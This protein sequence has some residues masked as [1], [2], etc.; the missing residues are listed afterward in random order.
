M[1]GRSANRKLG[2][3]GF[4]LAFVV[5]CG[6]T[7][8]QEIEYR[9]IFR[10]NTDGIE[11]ERVLPG[12][13]T[14]AW[15][16][17]LVIDPDPVDLR[18]YW[19]A[20][21]DTSGDMYLSAIRRATA[22]GENVH[23]IVWPRALGTIAIDS[24]HDKIYYTQHSDCVP[25][26]AISRAN[27]NGTGDEVV[28]HETVAGGLAID[29]LGGK[30][31]WAYYFDVDAIHCADLDGNGEQ[32]LITEAGGAG[33]LAVD[34]LAGKLYWVAYD[35]GAI[36]RA[37]LDG[38]EVEDVLTGL[39]WPAGLAIHPP[40]NRMWWS[41]YL[42]GKI[43]QAALDGSGVTDVLTGL[44]SPGAIGFLEAAGDPADEKLYWLSDP[45]PLSDD[46]P[47]AST[48]GAM[49][50][51]VLVLAASAAVLTRRRGSPLRR[52]ETQSD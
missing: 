17:P 30:I 3:A 10:A 44:D 5:L 22:D 20:L 42:E 9:S 33:S 45:A 16:S 18:L 51:V 31:Y 38:S 24:V 36:R 23:D 41:D 2:H 52:G 7:P 35:Q 11:V 15:S 39:S 25:C 43:Q 13:E 32:T 29:P 27:L 19:T 28:V 40:S 34:R 46:V 12:D 4:G 21:R 48:W 47:A 14:L 8:A 26:D 1:S 49:T 37:N 6:I 50:L